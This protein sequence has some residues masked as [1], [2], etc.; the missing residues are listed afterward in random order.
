MAPTVNDQ[1]YQRDAILKHKGDRRVFIETGTALGETAEWASRRFDRVITIE[2]AWN[3]Y[4]AA[5]ERFFH[6]RDITVLHGDSADLVAMVMH[7]LRH[8]AVFWL[9]AHYDGGKVGL[10]PSGITPIVSEL[11]EIFRYPQNHVI[12]VDDARLFGSGGYPDIEHV[13]ELALSNGYRSVVSD[14]IIEISRPS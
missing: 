11:A 10:A 14:D 4:R 5:E 7:N 12:L 2:Y 3:L 6:K 9:D 13:E 8:E 1:Q